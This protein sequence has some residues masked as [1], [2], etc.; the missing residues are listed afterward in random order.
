MNEFE[1]LPV[2]GVGVG[3]EQ[4]GRKWRRQ[5]GSWGKGGWV[6]VE[7]RGGVWEGVVQALHA[8]SFTPRFK[9]GQITCT[10]LTKPTG[11]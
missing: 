6:G 4:R 8:I 2:E 10:S 5:Q 3:R 9:R 7:G 11:L 1:H